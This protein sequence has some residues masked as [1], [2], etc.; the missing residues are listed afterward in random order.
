MM[1]KQAGHLFQPMKLRQIPLQYLLVIPFV[2]QVIGILGIT[3][4]LSI[5]NE[6]R[7]VN[8]LAGQLRNQVTTNILDHITNYMKK[9]QH[10]VADTQVKVALN[11]ID[12]QDPTNLT[13]YLWHQIQT[14]DDLFITAVGTESGTVSGVGVEPD[15]RV[16][17]RAIDQGQKELHTYVLK[18]QGMRGPL[19]KREAFALKN[20]PWYAA[21]IKAS[22]PT[23]TEIYLDYAQP[24][25]NISAVGPIY[26]DQTKRLIG[27]TNAT[28][29]LQKISQFLESLNVSQS[30]Q[31]F[32]LEHSGNLVAS[33]TG[34]N[35]Y[36]VDQVNNL[37]RNRLHGKDSS[38]LLVRETTQQLIKNFGNLD[39]IQRSQQFEFWLDGQRQLA[40]IAPFKDG[41]GLEWLV[42][43]VMPE[44]D[45][46]AQIKADTRI[47]IALCLGALGISIV[48]SM[49]M[50]QCL[51]R[52][53]DQ[54]SRATAG[55]AEEN[56]NQ[57]VNFQLGIKEVNILA[58]S[59]NRMAQRIQESFVAL[60][61]SES[62]YRQVVETQSD[63]I[64][65]S[66]PDT[67]ITFAN[68][69]L[70]RVMGQPLDQV[71]GVQW[72]SFI[73]P[74]D[75][76]MLQL[77]IAALTPDRPTFENTNCDYRSNDQV[78]WTQ[79]INQGIFDNHGHLI[80]I[81]SVGRDVTEARTAALLLQKSE[82]EASATRDLLT[83][84]FMRMNDGIV[85]LDT[86]WRY[87]YVNDK[88]GTMLG[89]P[90]QELIGK[91]IWEEFPHD[92]GKS[93]YHAYYRASAE[94]TPIFLEEYYEPWDRWFENRIF[95]DVHGLTIY[96]TEI[97][98]RKQAEAAR[99]Q[100]EKLKLELKLLEDILDLVL[101]G[102]WDWN[103]PEH[104]EYL[105]PSFKRMFGY[106][107]A[108]LPNVPE[109]WQRLI[110][111]EDLPGVEECFERHVQSRGQVPYYNEVRYRHKDG[112]TVWVICSG[113]VI[114]WDN[115]HRPLRMIGCH[116][117]ISKR[118]QAEE[119]LRRSDEHLR[120][121]QRVGQVGSWEF[122]VHTG[123]VSWS[124]EVFRIFGIPLGSG[125]PC[126]EDL[127]RLIHPLDRS[128]H[129]QVVQTT[130]AHA[131]PFEVECRFY[132]TDGTL[133]HFLARGEPVVDH[134]G[135]TIQL[136]GT[137]QDITSRKQAEEQ[138]L[139]LTTDLEASNRELEQFAY[140]ASHD[141]QE[142][143]RAV[144]SFAQLLAK[145]YQGKLD[146][147]ADLYI[148]LMVDGA[149]RMQQQI[150][151]LL[152]YSR[153]GRHEL[154]LQRVNCN[155]LLKR[156]KQDLNLIITETQATIH[157]DRLPTVML[158]TV[159]FTQL[160]ENL[161]GNALK[162][163]SAA[164]PEIHIRAVLRDRV[165][166]D[167][168]DART[169]EW[170]FSV[171]DNGIGLEPQYAER[172]FVI[173]QR[174]H[175]RNEYPGTGLGLAICQKI[176]ERHGGRIWVESQLGQGATFY[177]TLPE[178]PLL[179]ST[180]GPNP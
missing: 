135:Q 121:A 138:L 95:P 39:R 51:T 151:D 79:W 149:T 99:I 8:D 75:V 106:E 126:Y 88:A 150:R 45:F 90:A 156:V 125:T 141:L 20:R 161:I 36:T 136:I 64:M 31:T 22:K 101:A 2:F 78:G 100:S 70:C 168:S 60:Q 174:L 19:L 162:Y 42:V 143:L 92:I 153:V 104:Q 53:I 71:I 29:S 35:L 46:M 27:A 120:D 137:V 114:E 10:V 86:S 82:A 123:K 154:K 160:L 169:R 118:K 55:L 54:L 146:T 69:A 147:K 38:N 112:S 62:R 34:E 152:I 52:P 105:S 155:A 66:K 94:Q 83:N 124:E 85:A 144:S 96:F 107:E 44:S 6:Q 172:I 175:A 32:I 166:P 48:L 134:T 30:G 177:F 145:R 11:P 130:I 25:L 91:N 109:T 98:Q 37:A 68:L 26:D 73:S 103:I 157:A 58:Q 113:Q 87:T 102:Y 41:L 127:Q 119:R 84:V 14:H 28:I 170:L 1:T 140:V 173:F 9:P 164:S 133:G 131:C 178:V 97:T 116:I 81:Q 33:S 77:K 59:F 50:A 23:W 43:I 72:Q 108:E 63:F 49:I 89:R 67:T 122:E 47:I 139:Q 7:A 5:Q 93:F 56:F 163:R 61:N 13:R 110:F 21:G 132:R 17:I 180:S 179:S 158:D 167:A 12:P 76:E 16:V 4:W 24:M 15:G 57:R 115:E 171:Q 129:D 159:Q 128:L 74:E 148:E 3:G 165:D 142:P 65:R 176:I 18:D 40:Q 111:A 80:E 117:N